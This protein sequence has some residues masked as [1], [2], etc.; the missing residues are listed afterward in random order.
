M[1]RTLRQ[2]QNEVA[3]EE[4][5][6]SQTEILNSTCKS[7][8]LKNSAIIEVKGEEIGGIG[9]RIWCCIILY[10]KLNQE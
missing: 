8:G 10:L 4:D 2:W 6:K 9:D 5:G 7:W 3:V 1:D